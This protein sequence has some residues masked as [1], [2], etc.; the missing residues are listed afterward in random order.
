MLPA[1]LIISSSTSLRLPVPFVPDPAA[2]ATSDPK[3]LSLS[4]RAVAA[5]LLASFLEVPVPLEAIAPTFAMI[6]KYILAIYPSHLA[7]RYT[8]HETRVVIRSHRI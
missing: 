1:C 6:S 8:F 7:C 2:M 4:K 5:S 3:A